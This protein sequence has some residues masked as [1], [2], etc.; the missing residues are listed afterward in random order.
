[1]GHMRAKPPPCLGPEPI[2]PQQTARAGKP[3]EAPPVPP[4][5]HRGCF[6]LEIAHLPPD[7]SSAREGRKVW[8]HL[9]GK[10][11]CGWEV[12]G[13]EMV[14]SESY[15]AQEG[16]DTSYQLDLGCAVGEERAQSSPREE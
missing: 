6:S 11:L 1:M 9:G 10:Q 15:Q 8:S 14:S 12:E 4:L 5:P 2:L 13:L 16:C 3:W 7:G